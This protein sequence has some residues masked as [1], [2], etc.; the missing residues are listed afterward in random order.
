MAVKDREGECI[1][2]VEF[3]VGESI[4]YG[5]VGIELKGLY[6]GVLVVF[7]IGAEELFGEEE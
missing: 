2:G 6:K 7:G 4:F 5:I 1:D 3:G